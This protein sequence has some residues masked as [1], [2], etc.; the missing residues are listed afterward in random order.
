MGGQLNGRDRVRPLSK[1]LVAGCFD[2][3]T[4]QRLNQVN[5]RPDAV[6]THTGDGD[7]RLGQ[8]SPS[9]KM[10]S[11]RQLASRLPD[12]GY[13][14]GFLRGRLADLSGTRRFDGLA[15]IGQRVTYFPEGR[16]D[17]LFIISHRLV[18]HR[19]GTLDPGSRAAEIE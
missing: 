5:L 13:A 6:V 17:G 15:D 1:R 2:A 7:R 8:E 19:N 11:Q 18:L 10:L 4:A 3:S 16:Q 9:Q 12:L 14:E